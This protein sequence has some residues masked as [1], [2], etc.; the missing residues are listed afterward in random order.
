VS[1]RADLPRRLG[2]WSAAAVVIGMIVGSGI[3]RVPAQVAREVP[4]AWTALLLWTVGGAVALAG[5]LAI[6]ELAA[7]MPRAG[8]IYV[9]I[10][11]TYGPL[12]AFLL[13]W[14]DFLIVRPGSVAA[15]GMISA[16]YM[17]TF[18]PLGD[19][20]QRWVAVLLAIL[21]AAAQYRSVLLGAAVQNASSLLKAGALLLLAVLLLALGDGS[22][23]AF[24][25]SSAV[26]ALAPAGLGLALIAVLWAFD[27]W[28]D[29][30]A[31]GG[32]VKD[33]GRALPRAILGGMAAVLVLYLAINAAYLY[34][35]PLD[36]M[37][38]SP[39]VAADAATRVFG[40]AGA[41]LVAALVIVATFSSANA[42]M[43]TGPRLIFA[44]AAD[45]L[46]FRRLAA[47]HPRYGTPHVAIAATGLLS[48][49]Y[50]ASRTFEQLTAAIVLGE[51]PF[52]TLAVLA[53][54]LLRRRDPERARPYRAPLYP[55]LPALFVI[56]S[57]ALMVGALVTDTALTMLS[58]GIILSGLPVYW[59]WRRY[60]GP[61][62]NS[63]SRR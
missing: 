62:M 33:P 9:F 48:V 28:A 47:V 4:S 55:L 5:A 14:T 24:A 8:G 7:M 3:F 51:W 50:A 52:Y 13:G 22:A 21:L 1:A 2:T 61:F 45:G 27:G 49:L 11:E 30:A 59:L 16:G 32:E 44:M 10:R 15:L 57:L 42:V 6:A 31:L 17:S 34:V 53:V 38:G 26:S 25:G 37:A 63:A 12:P 20:A 58:F 43:M 18:F 29:V 56:A 23:G 36:V 41:S 19:A 54:I 60:A 46:F 40:R 39:L 35:L